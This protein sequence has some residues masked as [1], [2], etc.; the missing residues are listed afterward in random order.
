MIAQNKPY[1]KF[2]I[3]SSPRSGT[4][5]MRTALRNHPDIVAH[6]ELF[7]PDF[8]TKE[9]FGPQTPEDVILGQYIFRDYPPNVEQVGFI[10]HRSGAPFGN[11]PNLWSLL[12]ADKDLFVI[13]LRR[14]NLLRRY[15]SYQVMRTFRG[16][17]PTPLTFDP[18]VLERDFKHQREEI[19]AF[20]RRFA[21]HPLIKVH[22]ED[23]CK[24]YHRTVRSVQAFLEVKPQKL[25]PDIAGKPKRKLSEAIANYEELSGYFADTEWASFFNDEEKA[26]HISKPS[27]KGWIE[28]VLNISK[29][30]YARLFK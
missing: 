23:M 1:R 29:K 28:K 22:Y 18:E 16:A 14:R 2:I 5:M 10:I 20:D 30:G 8:L 7:N 4:H 17:P 24:D 27:N 15:L 19:D 25:W 26:T 9:P 3:L 12:Q 21:G 6:S 13:S 11:W